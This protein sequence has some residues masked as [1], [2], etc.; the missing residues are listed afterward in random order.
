MGNQRFDNFV[1]RD[2]E[3]FVSIVC[4]RGVVPHFHTLVICFFDEPNAMANPLVIAAI[5]IGH[6]RK[7]VLQNAIEIDSRGPFWNHFNSLPSSSMF[8]V[9]LVET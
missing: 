6:V 5:T 7:I 3:V 8:A 1:K 2:V 4:S 9:T